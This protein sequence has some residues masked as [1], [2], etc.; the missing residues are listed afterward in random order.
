MA[1]I[2]GTAL[3]IVGAVGVL[4]QI[5]TGCIDAYSLFT[6]ASSLSRDS[7]RLVCKI[8]IEEM[9]LLVWGREWG[10]AEGRLEEHLKGQS[11][12]L[13]VLAVDILGELLRTITDFEKL[14]GKYGMKEVGE[15]GGG[16]GGK[17]LRLGLRAKWVVA[18]KEKFTILLGDLKDYNDGLE[19]LFPPARLETLQR[20]W[21]N[22]LLQG[23]ERDLGQLDLLEKA[24][25][26]VYPQLSSSASLKQLRIN[27]D[28]K[29][30]KGF[31]PTYALK[32]QRT[33]LSIAD[34]N[35]VASRSHG[36]YKNPSTTGPE[37]VLVEWVSYD[38]EDLDARLNHV[39]R[40]DDLAR[41]IH[42][43]SHRH[44]DLHTLD[45][46]GYTD[47][48]TTSRYGLVYKAPSSSSSNL[49][50]L[51]SS[52]DLRTPD[53]GDRFKLAQTLAI[54]LWSLHSLDWLHK[55]LCTSNILFFPSTFS[56][57][58]T[59]S[60]AVAASIPD[61][62]SP[63]LLGFDASRP[64]GMGEMSV[65]SK[66]P[67]ASDLHRHPN[68]LNGISRKPYCKSYDI[69]SLGLVLLEIGLW[70]V[71]QTYHKPHYSAERF[72]D[73]IVVQNL[74]PNLSSKTGRLYKEVVERCLFAKEDL[75]GQE[76]G[77]LMEYVVGSLESLKV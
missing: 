22:E 38:K 5:F 57:S 75:T 34:S 71:L 13:R 44:P 33:D 40:I 45:C 63:F 16:S 19:Q 64:D 61:I 29:P 20:T 37:E 21:R 48:S 42:S 47:E 14:R 59:R 23:A 4:G 51:I 36:A 55:S 8:R 30:T 15:E 31:K 24:S 43:S 53:L 7:E 73:K 11:E 58:A 1:E 69:Y 46:I 66:N 25:S 27:L 74:V 70:K 67:A 65:A 17:G 39:R 12:R 77:Q 52:T 60:T 76:A 28:E 68:S 35:A 62:S 32:I 50:T 49:N 10:V 3:S 6:T 26:G 9:R 56:A 54:A 2:L 72:K 18:D 41:M